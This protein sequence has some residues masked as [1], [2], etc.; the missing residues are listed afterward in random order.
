MWGDCGMIY[1]WVRE[2][3]ARSGNFANA[4]LVLQCA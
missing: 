3:E 4:W 2:P 1:F